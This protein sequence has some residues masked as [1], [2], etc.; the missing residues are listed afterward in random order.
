MSRPLR[1]EYPGALYHVTS[2]ANPGRQVF[3]DAVDGAQYMALLEREVR[4]QRWLCHAY[5]LMPDHY[6]LVV[7]TPE[8]NLGRGMAR[9]NMSYSQWFNR[10]HGRPGHL[11]QGRYRAIL[12]EKGEPLAAVC[13]HVVLNPVRARL[14]N[15]AN[16]WRWSS[17]RATVQE[18]ADAADAEWLAPGWILDRMD[19]GN[20]DRRDAFRRYVE[21]GVGAAS[22]W[23][24]LH[25]GQYLGGRDFLADMARRVRGLPLAQVGRAAARPDRPTAAEIREAVADAADVPRHDVLDRTCA[26]EPYRVAAFL[27]RRACNLPLRQVAEMA[28]VSPGRISQIQRS[29]EDA[30]GLANAFPWAAQLERLYV[31]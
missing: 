4:Q 6:H 9:L 3:T 29:I 14:V 2:R 17:Y 5:C 10:Y 22:P 12:L 25:G 26:A 13:R 16:Q 18:T 21:D 1:I 28:G 24:D 30:G 8:P 27:L 20:G 23:L 19:D 7:E 31:T 15:H 11:F